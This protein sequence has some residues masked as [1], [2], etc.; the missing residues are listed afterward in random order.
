MNKPVLAIETSGTV[1]SVAV[2]FSDTMYAVSDLRIRHAHA[3]QILLMT[4]DVLRNAKVTLDDLSAIAVSIG[5]G[6]FTGLRIGLSAAK[7]LAMGSQ[8]P[9]IPVPTFETAALQ[10]TKRVPALN[11]FVYYS[12]VNS[13][14][15]YIAEFSV[16]EN[17]CTFVQPL[18]IIPQHQLG[19]F[20]PEVPIFGE[21][22]K[23]FSA[24]FIRHDEASA[25]FTGI[26]A[27]EHQEQK[28]DD[29]DFLEPMYIKEFIPK[30]SHS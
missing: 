24:E 23:L 26:W 2:V 22:L 13:D 14:E 5:P 7:G 17:R 20:A 8:L 10:I 16:V 25:L 9:I 27:L 11:R 19:T 1:C 15:L 3:E 29:F 18:Q 6:S 21:P 28:V 4:D 12:K 30:E